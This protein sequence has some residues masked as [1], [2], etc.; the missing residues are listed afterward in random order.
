MVS[1]TEQFVFL[2]ELID[3]EYETLLHQELQ[4]R[5][6]ERRWICTI[7]EPLK[8]EGGWI[9]KMQVNKADQSQSLRFKSLL[10]AVPFLRRCTSSYGAGHAPTRQRSGINQ[11]YLF[12]CLTTETEHVNINENNYIVNLAV[13]KHGKC[14]HRQQEETEWSLGRL[15]PPSHSRLCGSKVKTTL[16]VITHLKRRSCW[17]YSTAADI[18]LYLYDFIRPSRD[19]K[20]MICSAQLSVP[21]RC[22]LWGNFVVSQLKRGQRV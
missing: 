20:I 9:M 16:F 12:H 6:E 19:H 13:L 5:R 15:K 7:T 2:L 14:N 10:H 8:A 17:W 21:L 11:L 22:R 1:V 4:H 3:I 18:N